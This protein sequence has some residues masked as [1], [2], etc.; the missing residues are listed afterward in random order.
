MTTPTPR[1][2]SER[3]LDL[4]TE[5]RPDIDRNDLQHALAACHTA[6]WTWARTM[7]E[8]VHMLARG[9]EPR[10]LLN[11]TR[12]PLKLPARANRLTRKETP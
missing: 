11:A 2:A 1:P 7:T 8:T 9:E 12:N 4:A 5:T 3:L 10:D 6:G